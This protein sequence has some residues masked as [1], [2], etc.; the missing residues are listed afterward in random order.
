MNTSNSHDLVL[1]VDDSPET[2]GMLN[3]ALEQAGMTTLV[4]LEGRQ[5]LNIARKMTPDVILL[6]AVM[7][8]MD[9]FETCENLKRDLE[10][11]NIPVIFMTGLADTDN[12]VKGFSAGGVDYVTKPINP[13]ELIAR[14]RVHLN[15]ARATRSAQ[16]ALDSTGQNLCAVNKRGELCWATPQVN[17]YLDKISPGGWETLHLESHFAQWLKH[18]PPEGGQLQVDAAG[19]TLKWVLVGTASNNEFLLRLISDEQPEESG[20]LKNHF[21]VTQREAEVLLWVARGKTN[22]EIAQ[23]LEL[24]PRTVNKHLE[25]LFKKIG[26]ENRTS[27]A[28]LAVSVLQKGRI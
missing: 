20:L 1:V 9:G 17:H 7:P 2:L 28:T 24:S 5:A 8:N 19:T 15:N 25:Q 10:L 11:K 16:A 22:R 27:A 18:N 4:A 23:I 6:D 12:I 13:L 14:I 3:D 21:G 26:V